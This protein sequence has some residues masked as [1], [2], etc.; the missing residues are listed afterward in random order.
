M[1]LNVYKKH[2]INESALKMLVNKIVIL[3]IALPLSLWPLKGPLR[4]RQ[5]MSGESKN[6]QPPASSRGGR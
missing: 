1:R 4:L 5:G 2:L 3:T 6:A